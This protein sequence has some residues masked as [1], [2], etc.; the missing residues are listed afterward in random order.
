MIENFQI[1]SQRQEPTEEGGC[2]NSGRKDKRHLRAGK[3][4]QFTP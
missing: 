1:E 3:R 4:T 2:N